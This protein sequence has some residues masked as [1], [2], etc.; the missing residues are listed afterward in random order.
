MF[1]DILYFLT[2]MGYYSVLVSLIGFKFNV[3]QTKPAM[4]A[5]SRLSLKDFGKEVVELISGRF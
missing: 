2:I 4:L 1:C 5:V 3:V